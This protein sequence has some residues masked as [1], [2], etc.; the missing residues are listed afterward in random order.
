MTASLITSCQ[1]PG[2]DFLYPSVAAYLTRVLGHPFTAVDDRPWEARMT[3]IESGGALLG[4][5]CGPQYLA[6]AEALAPVVAPVPLGARYGG[7][8]VYFSDLVVRADAPYRDLD[9]LRG[10]RWAYNEPTSHSGY[11]AMACALAGRGLTWAHFDEVIEAGSHDAAI[12]M[13]LAG[14][15]DGAAIDS[16][17]LEMAIEA[18]PALAAALRVID[19]VGPSPSPPIV[20]QRQA[21]ASLRVAVR[22]ALTVMHE[23]PEGSEALRRAH[24]E[25]LAPVDAS[26]Y[27]VVREMWQ[28]GQ[29]AGVPSAMGDRLIGDVQGDRAEHQLAHL[30]DAE[31]V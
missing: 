22:E 28:R 24:I 9:G 27:E 30:A 26:D 25:R 3:L 14:G 29:A 31:T 21:D 1:A 23:D 2:V 8:P 20:M 10:A 13:I 16:T 19:S 17:V 5:V 7:R 4:H 11:G 6:R 12:A 15:V 18:A